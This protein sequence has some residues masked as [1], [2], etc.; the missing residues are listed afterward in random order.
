[1]NSLPLF[2]TNPDPELYL[3]GSGVVLDF[4]TTNLD[5]GSALNPE[6]RLLLAVWGRVEQGELHSI[7]S[8]FGSEYEMQ[9][10]LDA[11][12]S[13][14]YIIA[15]NAGFE[16]Q[17]LER[18]GYD[19]GSR[20]VYDTMVAEWV[21]QSNRPG[22]LDLDTIAKR[23]RHGGKMSLVSKLIK[24]GVNTDDI[25]RSLLLR[26]CIDD[27]VTTF[28]VMQ[29]QLKTIQGTRLLPIIYT[30]CLSTIVLSD[31][32]KSGMALDAEEVEA[33]YAKTLEEYIAVERELEEFGNGI[34]FNSGPQLAE[35]IYD[36]LGF[37][38]LIN[39]WTGKPQRTKGNRRKTD[40]DTLSRLVA[41]TDKQRQFIE[42]KAKQ[43]KLRAGLTKNLEFFLGVCREKDSVFY[44]QIAQGRT[45]TGRLASSGKPIKFDMF[46]KKKSCQF[47]N[48]PNQY[49]RLFKARHEGWLFCEADGSQLEFRVGGHLGRDRQI[50]D[51]VYS[52]ADIHSY[53]RDVLV[54]AGEQELIEA[55][56]A[57]RRRLAKPYCF[58]MHTEFL[59]PTGWKKYGEISVGDTVIN[60]DPTTKCLV[61]DTVI[62]ISE[63]HINNVI[64]MTHSHN[65]A[66]ESTPN[67]RWYCEKR[68][69]RGTGGRTYEPVVVTTNDI[70]SE[71]RIITSA[72]HLPNRFGNTRY[73]EM[74]GWLWSDGTLR[75]SDRE[76][77]PSRGHANKHGVAAVV[78]Q[79]KYTRHVE[80]LFGDAITSVRTNE[81]GCNYYNIKASVIRELYDYYQLPY[82]NE[83]NYS[84]FVLDLDY[85]ERQGW[86]RAIKLA[87][88]SCRH[89]D[90]WRVSQNS[91]P[92]AE[93]IKLAGFLVGHD[94]RVGRQ[95]LYTGNTNEQITFRNR[96]YVTG[97]RIVKKDL[98]EQ[99]VWCI[100][101]KN[102]T[103]VIRQGDTIS[104]SGNTFRP[105]YGGTKGSPAV[106]EYCRFF[107]D[108]YHGLNRT[109]EKWSLTAAESKQLETEWGMIFYFPNCE[110]T[111][112]GYIKG[113]QQV[114]NYPIQSFATAEII[115]IALVFFWFRTRNARMILTNTVHDSITCEVPPDEIELF[116]TAAVQALTYDVYGYLDKVYGIRLS[117][118]LGVGMK[119]GTHWGVTAFDDEQLLEITKPLQDMN[120]NPEIDDGEI[121]VD[122][123]AE[124]MEKL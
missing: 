89:G 122:V 116:Q 104:I 31:M 110:V 84:Q 67:H 113:K 86:L 46:E 13:C 105:M 8:H 39:P 69:D 60:Y 71:H 55:P 11:I 83:V 61:N 9:S 103:C 4:E 30:R 1:M 12:H 38:E 107:A 75:W 124:W 17:W 41:T 35:F 54:G 34:N 78:V 96:P 27:V 70:H 98:G 26:Y 16:L 92:L 117:I 112:S 23:Y 20:P 90:T 45:V 28:D 108:K 58:P 109:Q 18:C 81:V 97:Q 44:G 100:T 62:D 91:G 2:L 93:A 115:P 15:Q 65:W 77:G 25:P 102:K 118:P 64:R 37:A 53:T 106:E 52:Q 85:N 94:V 51:D 40:A 73:A 32:E 19:I 21:I 72:K 101:T 88:G 76:W 79:K 114:F 82:S 57:A 121:A 48:L 111:K 95:E 42:L 3:T 33:E 66:V 6:N 50:S 36:T 24:G 56:P 43:G 22:R 99:E 14:D 59:T 29:S 123:Y 5:K 47:Q 63:P 10:L 120:L 74:L 119:L 80:E 68:V 49:K 7:D 87:E